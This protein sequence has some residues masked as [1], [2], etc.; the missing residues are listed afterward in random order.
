M[1]HPFELT[2][3]AHRRQPANIYLEA[4]AGVTTFILAGRYLEARAKRRAGAALRALLELGA[5]DVVV[6]RDGAEVRVPVGE[7]VVGDLFV[8]RP[9][10]KIATDGVVVE[11]TRRSTRRC[12]PASRCRSRSAPATPSPARRSTPAAGW[13]CGPPGSART[14]SSPRWPGWSRTRRTA[15][16]QV[17]RLADR[18][19]GRLRAGRASRSPS[20]PSASGSAPARGLP[21]AFTA[22]VAVLII[23]CPCALGPG[24]ADRA[25]GRHRPRRAARHPDQGPRGARVAPAASTPSSSTRP[26]RSPPA[27]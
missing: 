16:P 1:T 7:L 26:A 22:A 12:S 27:G 8:V 24:H 21:A 13:S 4:A 17:Q 10:E 9:G 5:K 6:L 11:G 14:P 19:S 15:R 20:R 25:H 3:A 18:I 2:V 23:A